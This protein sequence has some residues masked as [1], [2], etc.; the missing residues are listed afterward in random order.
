MP[1]R[2]G[3]A[4]A[5]WQAIADVRVVRRHGQAA[6]RRGA[7]MSTHCSQH[8]SQPAFACTPCLAEE[9]TRIITRCHKVLDFAGIEGENQEPRRGVLEARIGL[10]VVERDRFRREWDRVVAALGVYAS[11][12]QSPSD[13]VADLVQVC[14]LLDAHIRRLDQTLG[15]IATLAEEQA[16]SLHALNGPLDAWERVRLLIAQ[17]GDWASPLGQRRSVT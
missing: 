13:N 2:S 10:V 11:P 7:L 4:A 12:A 1:L 5:E 6:T 15:E 3:D 9:G 16:A 17:V 8:P 14:T